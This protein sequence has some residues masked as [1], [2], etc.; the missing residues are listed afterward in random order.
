MEFRNSHEQAAYQKIKDALPADVLEK[1]VAL[2]KALLILDS[3]DYVLQQ[4]IRHSAQ[5]RV[6]LDDELLVRKLKD[7]EL[8][9]ILIHQLEAVEN[10]AGLSELLRNFRRLHMVRMIWRDIAHLANLN[11]TLEDLSELAD[12]CVDESAKLLYSWAIKKYGVPRDAEGNAQELIVIGMGK[13]GARELNLSSD[14]DLIFLYPGRGQTDG[15]KRIDNEQFFTRLARQLIKAIGENTAHG[16][17]FRVDTRL[18]PFGDSGPLVIPLGFLE[19]YLFSQAREWERYAMVKARVIS[20]SSL[21]VE[22][23]SALVRPFVFRRYLDYGAIESI[24]EMKKMIG[25]EMHARGMDANIKLGLGGIREIEFIGQAFQLIRG[26]REPEL[27]IRPIQ[28]VLKLLGKKNILPMHEVSDLLSAYE[29]LRLTENRLQAWKDEQTHILPDIPEQRERLARSMKYPDWTAFAVDL[30]S[31]RERVQGY[32]DSLFAAPQVEKAEENAFAEI[33]LELVDEAT[34]LKRLE[35]AGF[36]E[37]ETAWRRLQDFRHSPGCEFMPENGKRRLNQLMPIMLEAIAGREMMDSLLARIIPLLENIVRRTA[38][39]ALMVENPLVLSQLVRLLAKS[40]WVADQITRHPLLLDELIDPRNLYH[41]LKKQSLKQDIDS[42]MLAAGNDEE[43]GMERMRQFVQANML[44]VAAADLTNAIPVNVVSDYLSDIAEVACETVLNR[45]YDLLTQKHGRPGNIE[46]HE[47]GFAIIAYGKL[48]GFELG[49]SSDLD[50]VFLHSSQS[51]TDMTDGQKPLANDVFYARM[52]R[53]MIAEFT[54]RMASGQLYEIDMRLRPNGNSGLLV[55]SLKAFQNYQLNDAWTWEH[56]ALIR[57]RAI[58][59]D[60]QTIAAFEQIRREVLAVRRDPV[61]LQG[62]IRD[63]REK[64]RESLDKTSDVHFDLKQGAGGIA[65]IEFMVQ[66]AVLRWA[67]DYP[68]LLVWTDNA[69]LLETLANNSLIE[70][71]EFEALLAAYWAYRGEYHH[72]SL[73]NEKGLVGAERFEKEREI[74]RAMWQKL[75][76]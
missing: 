72:L 1:L 37:P 16:F 67:V 42:A 47:S 23:F 60:P 4:F 39:L 13:L 48:G 28:Q 15:D 46:G 27:Q 64:M 8:R 18:R 24:R 54:T 62:E 12:V 50:L 41:P 66:Y 30:Q 51:S 56:Q 40:E 33:W 71:S 52:A 26:G 29:F 21:A 74:V 58:A 53:K 70:Q 3:S 22:E 36:S 75:M 38:Y 49:Y 55:T 9:S 6:L 69:R 59:G 35:L 20:G 65:D 31:H 73:Q 43:Q 63:M 10:E 25:R 61:K 76:E 19:D 68:D 44:R 14:I 45:A 5:M 57:A 11:E 32:F 17:V 2:P 34:A 7:G